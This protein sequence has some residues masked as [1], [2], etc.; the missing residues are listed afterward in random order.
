MKK[1]IGAFVFGVLALAIR[2]LAGMISPV[3]YDMGRSDA[4]RCDCGK[5]G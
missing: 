3:R 4:I 2:V 5:D 1:I